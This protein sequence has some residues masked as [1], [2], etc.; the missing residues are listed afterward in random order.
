MSTKMHAKLRS[1]QKVN[2][3]DLCLDFCLLDESKAI[4]EYRLKLECFLYCSKY[5]ISQWNVFTFDSVYLF[6]FLC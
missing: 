6:N 2:G 1:I 5:N 4:Y 3:C